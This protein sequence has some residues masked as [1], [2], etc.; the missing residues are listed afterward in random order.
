MTQL[1][2]HTIIPR[3]VKEVPGRTYISASV[4]MTCAF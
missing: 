1:P 2:I 3:R 4:C